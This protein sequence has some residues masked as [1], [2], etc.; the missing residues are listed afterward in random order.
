MGL[1]VSITMFTLQWLFSGLAHRNF[2]R[3]ARANTFEGNV[4]GD[5]DAE[6]APHV[7][8]SKKILESAAPL[9][10]HDSAELQK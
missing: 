6:L 5:V 3:A 9:T 7:M 2:G 1:S 10:W 4:S 8:S